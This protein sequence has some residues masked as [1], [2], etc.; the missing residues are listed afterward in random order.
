MFVRVIIAFSLVFGM[1]AFALVFVCSFTMIKNL[2][3]NVDSKPFAL[4]FSLALAHW[5]DSE[6]VLVLL[7]Y[8]FIV[9]A[10]PIAQFDVN[11]VAYVLLILIHNAKQT[12]ES[13]CC[14]S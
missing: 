14:R 6:P 1:V 2:V 12:S 4:W 7:D 11:L 8:Y 10:I 13:F 3:C 5:P 9:Y